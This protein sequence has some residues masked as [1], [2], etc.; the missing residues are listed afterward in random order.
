MFRVLEVRPVI[1]IFD[2]NNVEFKLQ[3]FLLFDIQQIRLCHTA[4]MLNLRHKF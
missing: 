2:K 3:K 4:A 1:A